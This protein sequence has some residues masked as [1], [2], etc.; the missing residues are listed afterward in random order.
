MKKYILMASVAVMLM[1]QIADA[2][3]FSRWRAR[4]ESRSGRA[5]ATA[6]VRQGRATMTPAKAAPAPAPAQSTTPPAA[7]IK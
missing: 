6:R 3:L 2:G 7:P 4:R 5:V 1:T